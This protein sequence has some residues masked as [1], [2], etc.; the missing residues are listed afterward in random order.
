[1]TGRTNL[2]HDILYESYTM[3]LELEN[4]VENHERILGKNHRPRE[5]SICNVLHSANASFYHDR[6]FQKS[7]FQESHQYVMWWF[8]TFQ[9]HKDRDRAIYMYFAASF[10]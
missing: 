6:I 2:V 8:I 10:L 1:M 5:N 3:N 9:G 4:L 7:E